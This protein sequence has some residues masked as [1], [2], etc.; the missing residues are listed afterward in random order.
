MMAGSM[1]ASR[2]GT[3]AAMSSANASESYGFGSDSTE[4]ASTQGGD[5]QFML[6]ANIYVDSQKAARVLTPAIA[7]QLE[8][9]G[10]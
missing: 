8:W 9:D 5:S 7:K 2:V 3:G 1:A 10:K 6:E 4:A